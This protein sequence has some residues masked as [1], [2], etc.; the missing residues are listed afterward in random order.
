MYKQSFNAPTE[1]TA[2]APAAAVCS[3]AAAGVPGSS[4]ARFAPN[5]GGIAQDTRHFASFNNML[6]QHGPRLARRTCSPCQE[7]PR[8]DE[9]SNKSDGSR[10][11]DTAKLCMSCNVKRVDSDASIKI[12]RKKLNPTLNVIFPP[13]D[14][15]EIYDKRPVIQPAAV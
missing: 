1:E 14:S 8:S 11:I 10:P 9:M 2:Q 6:P 5:F 4:Y 7:L 3:H 15:T 12:G 13:V